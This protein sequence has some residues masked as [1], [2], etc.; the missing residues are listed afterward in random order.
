MTDLGRFQTTLLRYVLAPAV[1]FATFGSGC[2]VEHETVSTTEDAVL[3][4]R[5]CADVSQYNALP[6]VLFD[7][8]D[9][10]ALLAGA[11]SMC[12]ASGP[13]SPC[14]PHKVYKPNAA[15]TPRIPLVVFLPGTNM[16]PDKHDLV[17]QKAAFAEYKAIGLSYDNTVSAKSACTGLE[18]CGLDCRGL[19]RKEVILGQDVSA[20]V[21]VDSGDSVLERLYRV[22][23]YLDTTDPAGGWSAYYVPTAGNIR[24]SNI[25]WSNLIV[26]GFS[27]GAGHAGRIAHE[28]QVHGLVML[29]GGTDTCTDPATGTKLAAEWITDTPDASSGRP[30]YAV[31]HQHGMTPYVVPVGWQAQGLSASAWSVD[32]AFTDIMDIVP[33]R[34]VSYTDQGHPAAPNIC[35]DHMSIARDQCLPTDISGITGAATPPDSRLFGVYVRRFCY[36]CDAA[37]CP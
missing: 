22:L 28:K 19:M 10:V 32:G 18:E 30:K 21:T 20:Q 17:L 26:A 1:L 9:P 27:Q 24:A 12:A 15:V 23:E 37:T 4:L 34:Q 11:P 8:V 5:T 29:D 35:S 2:G 16:E 31:S 7:V 14:A 36:A 33:P 3:P 6:P 13:N 25:V